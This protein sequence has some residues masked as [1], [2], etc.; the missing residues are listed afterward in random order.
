MSKISGQDTKPEIIV[1]KFLFSK[2]F[3]YRKNIKSLPGTPDIVLTKYR[4]VIFVNGCFWHG[5]TCKKGNLPK[6]RRD[7]WEKKISNTQERDKRNMD[8]LKA[9]GWKVVVV[10][11]CELRNQNQRKISF[12][13]LL[14][15]L[16]R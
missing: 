1:R 5:H 11:Q 9:N 2:G 16:N 13:K 4:T 15:K 3:R 12:E 10:W 7:F 6:T 8:E 14:A